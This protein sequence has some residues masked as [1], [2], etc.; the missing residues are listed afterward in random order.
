MKLQTKKL[1]YKWIILISCFLMEFIC[2]G[3]GSSNPGLYTGAVTEAL[4]IPRSLYSIGTSIRYVV[5]VVAG[6]F[7]GTLI[8]K[9]GAKK[10]V[11]VGLA[12]LTGSVLIRGVATNIVHIYIGCALWGLGM[13]FSGGTMA[14]T[15][16]RR[17]F[18]KD[19]GKYTGIVMSAN[20]IGGAVAAQIIS[21]LINNGETFG[22][23]KAYFLSAALALVVSVIVLLCLRENPAEGPVSTEVGKKKKARGAAWTGIEFREVRKKAYFYLT[24]AMIFLTGISLQ[25]V[26]TISIV[27]MEDLGF[28]AGFVATT[29]T[30]SS[31]VLT[32]AKI[33]MGFTYDKKGL[34]FTLILSQVCVIIAFFLKATLKNSSVG[35]VCAMAATVLGTIALPLETVMIPLISNDLFGTASYDKVL[36]IF[37]SAN[38]LG[39]C[40]GSPLCDLYRDLT[41]GSYVACYWF[42]TALMVVVTIGFQFI[43]HAAHKDKQRILES[44]EES[45]AQ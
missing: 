24:F 20:G 41:G 11:L 10:M 31:L 8:Q 17:W 44:L 34:S 33:L 16:V 23:R 18:H 36:G 3:F 15:I 45:V 40:L 35:M 13:V 1:D 26:G 29:A 25:S 2:L 21:P 27:Y 6:L 42:F 19:I 7:F 32:F 38:S 4:G 30:V 43:I 12:S 5:Q 39:L 37:Y 28:D 9:F 14:S 22:Y